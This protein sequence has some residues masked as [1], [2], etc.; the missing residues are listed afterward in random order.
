MLL[1]YR[2]SVVT[3]DALKKT[4]D[5]FVLQSMLYLLISLTLLYP[6]G[7]LQKEKKSPKNVYWTSVTNTV[8]PDIQVMLRLA[9]DKYRTSSLPLAVDGFQRSGAS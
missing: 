2:M 1:I 4:F 3:A 6:R 5:F 9:C 7:S 8:I